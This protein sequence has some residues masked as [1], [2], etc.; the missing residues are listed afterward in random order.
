MILVI[1]YFAILFRKWKD[2]VKGRDWYDIEWYIRKG[3]TINLKH[4]ALRAKDSGD[5]DQ[6]NI[7][8][9]EFRELLNVKIEAVNFQWIKDNIRR[10]IPDASV[11][12]I[13][14]PQYFRD[15]TAKLKVGH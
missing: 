11:L 8:E 2:N 6:E 15:L 5:W 4:F 9:V 1:A 14:S 10:F 7:S 13:W 12:D 3:V